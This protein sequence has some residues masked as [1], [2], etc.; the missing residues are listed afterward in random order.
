MK[1]KTL[2]ILENIVLKLL[3]DYIPQQTKQEPSTGIH[4]LEAKQ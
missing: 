2:N 1:K 4:N 3:P